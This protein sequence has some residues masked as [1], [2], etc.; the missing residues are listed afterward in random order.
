MFAYV[1]FSDR[2]V[3][4]ETLQGTCDFGVGLCEVVALRASFDTFVILQFIR[5][6]ACLAC[7]WGFTKE[8]KI[9]SASIKL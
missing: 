2:K 7:I 6:K 3:T 8:T 5:V 4:F 1:F 9:D